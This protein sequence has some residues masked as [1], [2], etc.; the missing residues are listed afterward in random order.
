MSKRKSVLFFLSK[1]FGSYFLLF[2]MYS[3]YLENT[4]KKGDIFQCAPITHLVGEQTISVLQFFGC[5]AKME[6]H[7]SELSIKLFLD[8][9]YRARVIEGCNS[10]SL[11]ILFVSFI[12]A[13]PGALKKTLIYGSIGSF[14][15]YFINV[16]RI[17]FL[18]F[19]LAQFPQ[20][21]E[22]LHNL[23]FPAIIYTIVFLLWVIWVNYFSNY[24][25]LKHEEK[26]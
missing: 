12:I 20:R 10:V 11:I 16:L 3:Y 13:F 24:K 26:I 9:V 14:L 21:K 18:T 25:V 23:L 1:F 6:Q 4:Q 15:I 17:A 5:N 22:F 2:G 8:N 7:S 19:A